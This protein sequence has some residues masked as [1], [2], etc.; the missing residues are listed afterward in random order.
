[1]SERL[2]DLDQVREPWRSVAREL[3][4]RHNVTVERW[5]RPHWLVDGHANSDTRVIVCRLPRSAVTFHILAHEVGHVAERH[6]PWLP[7]PDY[8][9]LHPLYELEAE[10]FV[11]E[12]WREFSLPNR[13]QTYVSSAGYCGRLIHESGGVSELLELAR[14]HPRWDLIAQQIAGVTWPTLFEIDHR[15]R[16]V[17]DDEVSVSARIEAAL[18][19]ETYDQPWRI[20]RGESPPIPRRSG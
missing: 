20:S 16:I 18:T 12:T 6:P 7:A 11:I 4:D 2:R 3:L 1:M 15:G 5:A 14:W 8:D 17:G 10:R 19:S 13:R 9:L